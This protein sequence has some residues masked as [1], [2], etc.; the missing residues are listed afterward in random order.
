MAI[1]ELGVVETIYP[2]LDRSMVIIEVGVV[3]TKR[4]LEYWCFKNELLQDSQ[5]IEQRMQEEEMGTLIRKIL[6]NWRPIKLLNNV[7]KI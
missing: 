5:F 4:G 3:K 7:F 2:L 6:G 1:I